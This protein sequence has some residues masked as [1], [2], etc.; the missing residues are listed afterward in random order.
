MN[1][2]EQTLALLSDMKCENC[3]WSKKEEYQKKFYWQCHRYETVRNMGHE[4]R[5]CKQYEP[6]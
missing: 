4:V 5:W 1:S 6:L 3:K 2:L